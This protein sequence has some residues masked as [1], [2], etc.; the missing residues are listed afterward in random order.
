[1]DKQLVQQVLE[2]NV[3]MHPLK[4]G[5]GQRRKWMGGRQILARVNYFPLMPRFGL[6][7]HM[8]ARL[9]T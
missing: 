5:N 6:R 4:Q 7:K 9:N 1:M 3:E 8:L 2:F